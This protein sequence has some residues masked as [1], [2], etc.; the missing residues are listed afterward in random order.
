MVK[1]ILSIA[2]IICSITLAWG[3]QKTDS[4]VSVKESH[5]KLDVYYGGKVRLEGGH[6]LLQSRNV[7]VKKVSEENS[8]YSFKTNAKPVD[9][10]VKSNPNAP[11]VCFFLSPNGNESKNGKDYLGIFFDKI[12]G[13]EKGLTLWRYGPWN[14]WTK[15]LRIKNINQMKNWDVQFFYWQYSDGLYGAA[16]PL[17]GQGYRTTLGQER[18]SFGAKSVSYFNKMNKENIPQMAVGFGKDP[19]Q[20]FA[21][22]YKE[23]L[24]AI[25]KGDNLLANK[26]FP[27]IFDG[28]GWCS[29]NASNEGKNLN[30]SLLVNSAKSFAEGKFPVKW[31]LVDDG[32]FDNTDSKLNSLHPDKKKFPD[33]FAPVIQKL[34]KDYG[35]ADVGVWSTLNGYWQG[36]NP[37]SEL[38]KEYKNDLFSWKEK[39]RPDL[40]KSKMRTCY[41]ISPESKSLNEFYDNFY[42]YLKGQGFSFVKIDNQLVTERMAVNNFPIFEGAEKY[43]KAL[44][45]AVAKNFNNTIINCM[46]MTPDAYLNFGS[47]AVARAE[48]DYYP[49][50]NKTQSYKFV[51]DKAVGHVTQA[52]F[53]SLYFS[54]M[55]YPDFDMFESI[56]P[57]AELHAMTRAINNGPV[58]ITDKINEHNFKV[59]FPL[60]Y[61]DGKILRASKPL[62]PTE[63]CL[64]RAQDSTQFKAFSMD[65]NVGLLAIWNIPNIT[66]TIGRFR[67]TDVYQIKGQQFAVYEYFRKEFIIVNS[68]QQIQFLPD[69]IPYRLYYL[70]PMSHGSAVIGLVNKYN[71]PAA[72]LNSKVSL[73]EVTATIYEGGNFAAFIRK[74]PSMVKVNGKEHP[75]VYQNGMLNVDIAV[76]GTSKP[77]NID[78]LLN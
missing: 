41:F 38:G 8:T 58:Y 7:H 5:N 2:I 47:T 39:V 20:L 44:N 40:P 50:Y 18:N 63:D 66:G 68:D 13:F 57:S 77:V 1:R 29:W 6:F 43:H 55:V 22:L 23:G 64:F 3:Q 56:S 4:T 17:S 70:I 28:I 74:R 31:F 52:A 25:G 32:W 65:G 76:E 14:S 21:T 75:F 11:I 71:A 54:Q 27:K 34:K 10:S 60:V 42:G 53:N 15:P 62:L 73:N 51:M 36:I 49:A 48:D 30:D 26:T 24:E 67:P 72:V 46:D 59:L 69:N 37:S 45:A 12:P 19:Y 33:G 16:M 35:I 9:V 61:S 78:I